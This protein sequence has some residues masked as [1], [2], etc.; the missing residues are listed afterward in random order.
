MIIDVLGTGPNEAILGKGKNRRLQS[1]VLIDN[2][3]LIDATP[4]IEKQLRGLNCNIE[5]ILITHAHSDCITG[6]KHA[7]KFSTLEQ[8]PIYSFKHTLDII[9]D[10]LDKWKHAPEYELVEV[11]PNSEIEILGYKVMAIPVEHSVL[12]PKFDP[13]IAWLIEDFLYAEDVDYEFFES[14]KAAFLLGVMKH[15]RLTLLDGAMCK[16]RLRGHLNIWEA[17]KLLKKKNIKNVFFTQIGKSCPDH[18]EL[19]R[20]I[21][22]Y[23]RTFSIA[24]D[25]M[26]IDLEDFKSRLVESREGLY[27][28]PEHAHMIWTGSK[29]L[30]VKKKRFDFTV[31]KHFYLVGGNRC[32][33]IIKIKSIEPI[34]LKEFEE[35]R[36]E[37]KIT[38]EERKR[39]WPNAKTLYAYRFELVERFDPPKYVLVPPGTQTFMTTVKFLNQVEDF[40]QDVSNYDPTRVP[41]DVLKDDFRIALAWYSTKKRGGKIKYS[42]EEILNLIKIIAQELAKRGIQFHP[43][44]MKPYAREAFEKIRAE[45]PELAIKE[46]SRQAFGS[47]GG[48]FFLVKKLLPLIPPHKTYVE[49]FAGGASLYFRKEPSEVEVLNDLDSE[50]AFAYRFIKNVTDEQIQKLKSKEWG[51]SRDLFF[52]LRDSEIPKDPVERF[53]RFM[54][55]TIHSYGGNRRTFGYK[56]RVYKIPE[57]LPELKER[58]KNTLIYNKDYKE[59]LHKF[60]APDT[61][62]YL[63][64]P[65]PG[66]WGGNPDFDWTLEDAKELAD[67]LSKLKGKFLLSINYTP[68]IVKIFSK[69]KQ[70]K[71]LVPRRF[72]KKDKDEYELLV[73]NYNIDKHNYSQIPEFTEYFRDAVL[74]KDAVCLVGSSVEKP[75]YHDIDIL[76]RLNNPSDFLKRAI[77]TRIN[78]MLPDK[79]ADK[80]H[81]IWGDPEG[82]HDTYIPLF[83]LKLSRVEPHIVEM[84][85]SLLMH[86]FKPMKP[87]KRFYKVEEAVD[88]IFSKSD[89]WVVEKKYNG[90]RAVIHK[91][92]NEVKIYSDQAKDITAGFPT[93]VEQARDLSD[94]DFILDCE[95]VPYKGKEPLGRAE[96]AKYIGAVESGKKIDDS[97]VIFYAFDILYYNKPLINEPWYERHRVLR[98]LKSLS[99]IRKAEGLVVGTR[100]EAV[101]AINFMKNLK[102]SEGAMLKR[103]DGKYYPNKV[104][105][106]WVKYRKELELNLVVLK[107]NKIKAK[108]AVNYLV[109]VPVSEKDK[110]KL[111]PDYIEGNYLVLGNTF[112]TSVKAKVGDVLRVNVEEVWRHESD[113]KIRFS[114]HKPNVKGISHDKPTTVQELD[115]LVVARGSAVKQLVQ[116]GRTIEV[117]DF[118]KRLQENLREVIVR[119]K[120]LRYVYQW[121]YRGHV[122]KPEER[123]K[124]NIPDKYKYKLDSLHADLRLETW[125]PYLEG[126]TILSPTSTDPNVPNLVGPNMKHVRAVLKLIQPKGWLTHEGISE[127]GHIAATQHAPAVMVIVGK[128]KYIPLHVDDH[129]I[130]LR[131]Y[132]ED[133]KVNQSVYE[134]ADK[135]GILITRRQKEYI[136]FSK[137][138][139][140]HIAHIEPKKWILLVDGVPCENYK[141][142]ETE[143]DRK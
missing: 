130:V 68:E 19:V 30:I 75:N 8:V 41:T 111:N 36:N 98:K 40:I 89:K 21:K 93:A 124:E 9:V 51:S 108:G 90:F 32:F 60:D 54:Y 66:E 86:P 96:A 138:T 42:Y 78:K 4:S 106:V 76:I 107:V 26:R 128:G 14:E 115:K 97:N 13:T 119:G 122:I 23:D 102:G 47:Y 45:L 113:G 24:Y 12:Q 85:E 83:D 135:K 62:F 31:G 11:K 82:P 28:V 121:H 126:I 110:P 48:K 84:A 95:L 112:N 25:D 52:K 103:Y 37:H 87:K 100:E 80:L 94:A 3:M 1:S 50:V 88:Y 143:P 59:V 132:P 127:P 16:G 35:L 65:Y 101:K 104:S 46:F 56:N 140:F 2:R 131:F 15:A 123:E 74:V 134:E 139:S 77:M 6:L 133:G 29:T 22:K 61:F 79:Y 20:L 39:W 10:K 114:I 34:T 99:N 120:P 92:G 7:K 137:C 18:D 91:K 109:G 142:P 5:A 125:K 72:N 81:F 116:V 33:G 44:K 17:A 67:E 43:E 53:Y 55:I 71:I 63:D 73:Y 57:R 69:F 38:D 27:L 49:P 64:P 129:K 118:P 117:R 105:D 58:L 141:Q 70:K 136:K